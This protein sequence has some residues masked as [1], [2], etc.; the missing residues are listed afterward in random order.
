MLK[1]E[2]HDHQLELVIKVT[3]DRTWSLA[4]ASFLLHGFEVPEAEADLAVEFLRQHRARNQLIEAIVRAFDQLTVDLKPL[5]RAAPSD[6][7]YV[8]ATWPEDLRPRNPFFAW[9][10]LDHLLEQNRVLT[11]ELEAARSR[12]I[13]PIAK[14]IHGA[15]GRAIKEARTIRAEIYLAVLAKE[16]F[17]DLQGNTSAMAEKLI[18]LVARGIGGNEIGQGKSQVLLSKQ[19]ISKTLEDGWKAAAM[20]GGDRKKGPKTRLPDKPD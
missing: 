1:R 16:H 18:E 17:R 20:P 11:E 5:N 7:L 2:D 3:R 13:A 6:V 19:Q 14:A 12:W 9:Q 15:K 8:V 10:A 4:Y